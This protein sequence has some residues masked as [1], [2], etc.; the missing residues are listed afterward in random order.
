VNRII[1]VLFRMSVAVLG[2]L[3][4][5]SASYGVLMHAH[6]NMGFIMRNDE[7]TQERD[8]LV[9][10]M[11]LRGLLPITAMYVGGQLAALLSMK[12]TEGMR[13][14][15]YGSRKTTEALLDGM[16]HGLLLT[17]FYSL[18]E[19]ATSCNES[20]DFSLLRA[21]TRGLAWG[22]GMRSYHKDFV[23]ANVYEYC[24]EWLAGAW[25]GAVLG[26]GALRLLE[27]V[28]GTRSISVVVV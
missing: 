28:S 21:V 15:T 11:V 20:D 25:C 8:G 22:Y 17:F 14:E 6:E 2:I 3:G 16:T 24:K 12:V 1:F 19:V 7:Y 10:R 5:S 4:I 18:V 27:R 26:Y 9:T 23:G 13:E